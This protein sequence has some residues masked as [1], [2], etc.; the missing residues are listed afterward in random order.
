MLS[1]LSID[2]RVGHEDA[3]RALAR[4][5]RD[6]PG[7]SAHVEN[8]RGARPLARAGATTCVIDV[9][10]WESR[11]WDALACDRALVPSFDAGPVEILLAGTGLR[12]ETALQVVTRYQRYLPSRERTAFPLS[13]EVFGSFRSLHDLER[14]LVRADYDHAL[15]AWTWLLRLEPN[16]PATAQLG[17]L[18][19]DVER[20]V[21]EPDRRVEQHAQ[22]YL[23]FK[24]AHARGGAVMADEILRSIGVA[25]GIRLRVSELIACHEQPLPG[26]R[27]ATL[28]TDADALSFFSLNS[29]GY[30]E[31]FGPSQT[32]KKVLYTLDRLS[33]AHQHH[34]RDLRL[35][36]AVTEM[37]TG[38]AK[39][40]MQRSGEG[41]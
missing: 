28:L 27:E 20:L 31:Y 18:F 26:D 30:L 7:L 24:Q 32:R 15:D 12:E 19:H 16:A 40:T 25:T 8:T 23:A 38:A 35:P 21:T 22:D 33:L 6:F 41:E 9:D 36:E 4:L 34:L 5:K 17:I 29:P 2:A 10:R 13:R 1:A 14:P 11:A 37:I 3:T 39:E